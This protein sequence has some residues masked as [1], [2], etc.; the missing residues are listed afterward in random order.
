[1]R[2]FT[3]IVEE[4]LN[5][6]SSLGVGDAIEILTC[7]FEINDVG[8]NGMGG[9]VGVLEI[10]PCLTLMGKRLPSTRQICR[11]CHSL[12]AKEISERLFQ[13]QIVPPFHGDQVPEPHVTHFVHD[14]CGSAGVLR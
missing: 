5:H 13:P 4:L 12:G 9:G 7:C 2:S 11:V 1:K 10:G 8:D 14:C 3:H 6:G